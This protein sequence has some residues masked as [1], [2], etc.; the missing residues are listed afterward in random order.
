MNAPARAAER[1][2]T[3]E[4]TTRPRERGIAD[5]LEISAAPAGAGAIAEFTA[6][7]TVLA[8]GSLP[9]YHPES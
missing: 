4:E 3:I 2:L 1:G 8:C 7:G 9:A 6:Q 5:R